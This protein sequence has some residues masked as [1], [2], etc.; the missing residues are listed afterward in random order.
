M[1]GWNLKK[2]ATIAKS[3]GTPPAISSDT[4]AHTY[5]PPLS[6]D[7][8]NVPAG[9]LQKIRNAQKDLDAANQEAQVWHSN[10]VNQTPS[11]YLGPSNRSNQA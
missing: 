9:I 11:R 1:K 5:L 8:T 4:V 2:N 6:W 7:V 10:H 3:S